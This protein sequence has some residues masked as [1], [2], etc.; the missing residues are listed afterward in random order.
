[1]QLPNIFSYAAYQK[2]DIRSHFPAV[3]LDRALDRG[4]LLSKAHQFQPDGIHQRLPAPFDDVVGDADRKSAF[5][6]A[7]PF[8]QHAHIR[9]RALV[10]V[11]HAHF[12]VRQ[13][14]FGAFAEPE[15]IRSLADF[16]RSRP[17]NPRFYRKDVGILAAPSYCASVKFTS[18]VVTTATGAPFKSVGR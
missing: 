8:D 11:A 4:V 13:A 15:F 18:M 14:N 6:V 3:I 9:G 12:V 17:R 10:R 2:S 16:V 5:A 1:M 7:A